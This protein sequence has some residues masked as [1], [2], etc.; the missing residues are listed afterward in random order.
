MTTY[1]ALIR[2][3]LPATHRAMPLKDLCRACEAEG[4]T[5][6]RSV[7]QTGNLV[8]RSES[9]DATVRSAIERAIAAFGLDNAIFVLP[10][11][12]LDR[13]IAS[14]PYPDAVAERPGKLLAYV[15][16]EP[17]GQAAP[18]ALA[19]RC[20]GERVAVAGGALW[21]DY[22]D[23]VGRSPVGPAVAERAIGRPATG[24]N[25]NT[26]LRLSRIAAE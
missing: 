12:G 3:I 7:L 2:A 8:C 14:A 25:W 11:D 21:I 19:E 5:D 4:L 13:L 26:L 23:G 16:E 20:A 17:V 10:A 15:A 22:R 9:D 24:R 1:V 6:V 18:Q